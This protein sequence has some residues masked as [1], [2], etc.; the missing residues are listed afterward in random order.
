MRYR[1]YKPRNPRQLIS[2]IRYLVKLLASL[3][4]MAFVKILFFTAL[5]CSVEYSQSSPRFS[6]LAL[7]TRFGLDKLRT[8]V[9]PP[10]N[11]SPVGLQ[12]DTPDF[13][14]EDVEDVPAENSPAEQPPAVPPVEAPAVPP[15]EAPA[16]PPVE[17]PAV[18]PVEA[19][20]VPPVEAP[21]VS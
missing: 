3:L 21:A 12:S 5:F 13:I 20:A 10:G 16:V 19:P 4:K 18:P 8:S 11:C 6:E 14:D 9:V 17:A 7:A 1:V 2:F 15:V